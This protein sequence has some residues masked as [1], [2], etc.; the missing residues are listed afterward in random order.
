VVFFF[1][2][3]RETFV[4]NLPDFLPDRLALQLLACQTLPSKRQA[5]TMEA[6]PKL[7][8]AGNG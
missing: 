6:K 2:L 4:F 7:Q 5:A 8:A 1:G 3:R